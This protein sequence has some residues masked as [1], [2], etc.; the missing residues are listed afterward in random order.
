MCDISLG[1]I[2]NILKNSEILYSIFNSK[3]NTECVRVHRQPTKTQVFDHELYELFYNKRRRNFLIYQE[4]IKEIG[5][6]LSQKYGILNFK[7]SDGYIQKFR[8]RHKIKSR[9]V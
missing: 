2:N 6:I 4:N 1:S 5:L 7:A 9:S 8:I 3:V